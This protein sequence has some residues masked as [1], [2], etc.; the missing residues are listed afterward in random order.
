MRGLSSRNPGDS[1][2]RQ[3]FSKH[4]SDAG[5]E[6]QALRNWRPRVL[7]GLQSTEEEV[8]LSHGLGGEWRGR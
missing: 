3:L 1:G 4:G 7:R 8:T 5:A 2:E 6:V